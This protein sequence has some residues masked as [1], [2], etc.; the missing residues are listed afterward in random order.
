M[1]KSGKKCRFLFA[2]NGFFCI[3]GISSD[4]KKPLRRDAHS[5]Q[6]QMAAKQPHLGAGIRQ[7]GFHFDSYTHDVPLHASKIGGKEKHV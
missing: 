5:V 6:R 4:T 1:V 2:G 3:R 7:A